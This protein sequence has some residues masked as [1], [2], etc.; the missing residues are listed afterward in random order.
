MDP[1]ILLKKRKAR[2]AEPLRASAP[3]VAYA[4]VSRLSRCAAEFSRIGSRRPRCAGPQ[5]RRQRRALRWGARPPHA[6]PDP[7]V[8]TD[9]I[10]SSSRTE[11]SSSAPI[12][13]LVATVSRSPSGRSLRESAT[14]NPDTVAT[15]KGLAPMRKTGDTSNTDTDLPSV[16]G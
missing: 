16:R 9:Q 15:H 2:S 1:D 3:S 5:A 13:P 7:P 8:A 6:G 11:P 14:P 4:R 12:I 10:G